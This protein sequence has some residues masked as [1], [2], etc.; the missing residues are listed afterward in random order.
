MDINLFRT[1]VEL[2][3]K[4]KSLSNLCIAKSFN[5]YLLFLFVIGILQ[6]FV[7]SFEATG[8]PQVV[9]FF[10][11]CSAS[12]PAVHNFSAGRIR[13]LYDPLTAR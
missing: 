3:L 8:L 5:P 12:S 1:E 10:P 7:D 4:T 11:R 13:H 9:L 6:L 2:N